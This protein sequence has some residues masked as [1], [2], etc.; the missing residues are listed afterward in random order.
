MQFDLKRFFQNGREPYRGELSFDLS[1]YDFPG[2]RVTNP[3]TGLFTAAPTMEGVQIHL[4]ANA[5]VETECARCLA[6]VQEG[7]RL[8]RDWLVRQQDLEDEWFELPLDEAG[9]LDVQELVCE[10]LV[11]EVPAVLLCSADCQG[12]C[13][14]CG[15]PKATGN[16]TCCQEGSTTPVDERL[17]ILKQ[18]LN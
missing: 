7:Y 12:L 9:K 16:C 2:Y 3:V 10:E 4:E 11:V 14:V 18:L 8:E 17:A 13:H 5:Q 15:N 6:P 1:D